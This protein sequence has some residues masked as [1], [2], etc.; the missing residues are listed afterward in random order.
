VSGGL[1]AD[2]RASSPEHGAGLGSRLRLFSAATFA[3][4]LLAF[5][6]PFGAVSSCDGEEVHFT[7]AQLATFSVPPDESGGTLQMEVEKN[8]GLFAVLVLLAAALGVVCAIRGVPGGG[9]YAAGG[10]LATQLL[11]LAVLASGSG[12]GTLFEG[13]WLALGSLAAA[14]TGHLVAAVRQRRRSGRRVWGYA[15]RNSVLTLSPTLAVTVLIA[16]AVLSEA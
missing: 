3:G 4:A 9:I 6:L 5:A 14:C 8:A 1:A 13:F 10:L 12:G 7:G 16:I 11:G 15:L 2:A